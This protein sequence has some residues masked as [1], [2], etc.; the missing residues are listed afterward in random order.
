MKVL[1]FLDLIFVSMG[2]EGGERKRTSQILK[3]VPREESHTGFIKH[4]Q[5]IKSSSHL[6]WCQEVDEYFIVQIEGYIV[7]RLALQGVSLS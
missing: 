7:V 3:L 1:T 4:N 5:M 6:S 2:S